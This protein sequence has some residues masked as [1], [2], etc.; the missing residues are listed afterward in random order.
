MHITK[1]ANNGGLIA[2]NKIPDTGNSGSRL[3]TVVE[4][5]RPIRHLAVFLLPNLLK[6]LQVIPQTLAQITEK[7]F[8]FFMIGFGF[9]APIS[10][11]RP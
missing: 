11:H 10:V 6:I 4:A 7:R 9:I 1:F 5:R 8:L 2:V 3:V